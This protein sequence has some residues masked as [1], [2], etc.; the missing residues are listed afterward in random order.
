MDWLSRV[1]RLRARILSSELFQKRGL[2]S[3]VGSVVLRE[4]VLGRTTSIVHPVGTASMRIR[5]VVSI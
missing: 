1:G 2:Q 5:M 3:C 4:N